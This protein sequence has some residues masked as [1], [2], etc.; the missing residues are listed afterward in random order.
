M[1]ARKWRAATLLTGLVAA[2]ATVAVPPAQAHQPDRGH[3]HDHGSQVRTVGY[4]IQWGIYARDYHAANLVTSGTAAR[5]T[6]LNYAFGSLDEQ[7]N[8][9]SADAWADFQRPVPAEQSVDGVADVAG[10]PVSGNLNQLRKLKVKYPN[11]KVHIS[12]GGW[13][14]SKYFS[15][16]ALTPQS[17]ANHVKSCL[18]GWLKGTI[19]GTDANGKGLA[20]GIIDG[21]DLDWEWP[22]STAGAPGNVVRPEDKVNFTALVKEYRTQLDKFPGRHKPE[23]TAYLP[24]NSR[25]IDKGFEVSKVFKYLDFGTVQGYDLHG[26]WDLE[27]N[28]QS[29]LRTPKGDP[30]PAPGY[31]TEVTIDSY[32]SRGAPRNK[33]VLGVPFFGRGW[34]G[35]TNANRGLF[36][37]A[38]AAAPGKWEAG[39]EDY[40]ELKAKVGKD[41][42]KIYRDDRAGFSWIFNGTTFWTYDDPTEMRRKARYIKDRCLGGAMI[43]SLDADTADG[44]LIK[45]LH[46]ELTSR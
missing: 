12:L 16:A 15:N 22:A 18:D 41:G 11:L 3:G 9:V 36:Q 43:W 20:A 13:S 34:T 38:T 7:G 23:L 6:H 4:F 17:R 35:V 28:Q 10:Q 46:R 8:C 21:V 32:L 45:S 1:S 30:T 26:A 33:L 27:T 39:G 29:A 42:F 37:K 31:S 5:L 24:A 25:E 40:K 14:G 19:A 2:A 44:E